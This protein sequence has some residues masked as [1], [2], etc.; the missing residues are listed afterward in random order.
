MSCAANGKHLS[1][2]SC[3][4]SCTVAA[5]VPKVATENYIYNSYSFHDQSFTV[6]IY[7][8]SCSYIATLATQKISQLALV[9]G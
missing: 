3:S 4:Y 1:S 5:C 6:F 9:S 8:F 7:N 2:I